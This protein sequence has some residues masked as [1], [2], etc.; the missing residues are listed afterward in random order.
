MKKSYKQIGVALLMSATLATTAPAALPIMNNVSVAEAASVKLSSKNLTLIIGQSQL[1]K[2]SGTSSKITWT[3]KNKS[4]AT[5]DKKGKV[6]AKKKGTTVITASVNGKKYT[7]KVTVESP[8]LNKTSISLNTKQS[9]RLKLNGTKQKVK[10]VSKNKSI[11]TVNSGGIVTAKKA[12]STVITASIGKKQYNC[13]I[14]VKKPIVTVT[15]LKLNRTLLELTEEQSFK[16]SVT[17]SPA[18]ATD[19]TVSWDSSNYS[20]V[21]VDDSGNL[22]A[23]SAGSAIIT[24]TSGN[25]SVRCKVTVKEKSIPITSVILSKTALLLDIDSQDILQAS[26]MPLNTT[27]D[28]AIT[29]ESSDSS[30]AEVNNG[31]VKGVSAGTATITATIGTVKAQCVVQVNQT[32]GSVNGNITY[33]Y[34][35]YR[36]N[37]PDTDSFVILIPTDGRAMSLA[38]VDDP[39]TRI[40]GNS[41]YYSDYGIYGVKVDGTGQYNLN[42]IPTGSYKML[43][44]SNGTTCE[45]WFTDSDAYYTRIANRLSSYLTYSVAY[46]FGRAV[47][48]HKYT[49]RDVT[50][51]KNQTSTLSYDFGIT[52]I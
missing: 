1:L 17:V 8:K 24:A 18:N 27:D 22:V 43:I 25:K 49:L 13:K 12:G 50:I 37:V 23:Y 21:D 47:S 46:R 40:M 39:L 31:I 51:V 35:R 20:V 36:G 42:N 29:W 41:A 2:L 44:K 33:Y 48:Y 32:Y 14:T 4:I 45:D 16:L 3:T 30:I 10:W 15:S 6:T 7:C 38:S 19:K 52:Y 11:A 5:V 28:T 26:Y 34:N 9:T